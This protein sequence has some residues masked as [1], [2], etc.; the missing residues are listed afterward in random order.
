LNGDGQ[1]DIVSVNETGAAVLLG[2]GSGEYGAGQQLVTASGP[3]QV[4]LADVAG[5]GWLDVIT[6]NTGDP[7]LSVNVNQGDGTFAPG[8]GLYLSDEKP[9][10]LATG[11]LNE[12]AF[13]D[14]AITFEEKLSLMLGAGD[15][16][17]Y[18]RT[19]YPADASPA[20]VQDFDRDG[21]LD[22]L[23]PTSNGLSVM[24]GNGDFTFRRQLSG[25]A[26]ALRDLAS[27]D[28]DGDGQ[29][30][31]FAASTMLDFLQGTGKGEFQ[32]ERAYFPV[33][34]L[35]VALG[36]VNRDQKL[37]VVVSSE[38]GIHLLLNRRP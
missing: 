2:N 30:D 10:W 29:L 28:M 6:L 33:T 21:H 15:G 26:P 1:L 37:D 9:L 16:T 32:C 22:I 4:A 24:L 35:A 14:L 20:L 8:E 23:A 38:Q 34:P 17:F 3:V 5:D 18:R 36:D 25:V 7:H 13:V 12:D 19:D 31:L 11:D 27:G